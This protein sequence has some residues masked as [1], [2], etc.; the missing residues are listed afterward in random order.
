MRD[1]LPPAIDLEYRGNCQSKVSVEAFHRQLASFMAIIERHYHH[2]VTLYLTDEFDRTYRVSA[3]VDRSL[4]LRGIVTEPR[5][6]AR[7]WAM[8]QASNFRRL[9]GIAGRV[10]WNVARP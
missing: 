7:P 4:W 8:W 1:A 9:P 3:R 2:P 6:G 5:F 10:D